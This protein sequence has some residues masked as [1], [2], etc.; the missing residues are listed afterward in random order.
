M[1]G[2][3]KQ[4]IL[5]TQTLQLLATVADLEYGQGPMPPDSYFERVTLELAIWPRSD[6]PA[7]PQVNSGWG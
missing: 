6:Q 1:V 3:Q 5:E 7:P 4:V 2:P